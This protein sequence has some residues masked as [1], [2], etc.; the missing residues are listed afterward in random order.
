MDEWVVWFY[1]EPFTL[2]LNRNG[3]I[4]QILKQFQVVCFNY[5]SMAFK[6]PVLVADTASVKVSA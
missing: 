4:F 6:C 3:A 5:I 2:H 1:A